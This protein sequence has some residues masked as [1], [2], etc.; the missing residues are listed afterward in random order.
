MK[1]FI[2]LFLCLT[3][4]FSLSISVYA[5]DSF[6]IIL[7]YNAAYMAYTSNI[8]PVVTSGNYRVTMIYNGGSYYTT[9]SISINSSGNAYLSCYFDDVAGSPYIIEQM[10]IKTG[11]P[12]VIAYAEN[13]GG[14]RLRFEKI[15]NITFE[16]AATEGMGSVIGWIGMLLN[17]LLS[18]PLG[19]LL[20]VLAIGISISVLM[21]AVK[22]IFSMR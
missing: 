4:L 3:L 1:K 5:A 17:D 20:I 2:V 14:Y 21:F 19:A 22:L 8:K 12:A 15:N 18:G 13:I 7:S 11:S 10:V 6:T 9:T 16:E